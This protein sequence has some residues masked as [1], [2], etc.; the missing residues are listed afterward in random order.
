MKIRVGVLMGGASSERDI[1]LASGKMIADNLPKDRYD[2]VLLDTL[3]LMARNSNLP[4]HLQKRAHALLQGKTSEEVIAGE[5]KAALPENFQD[6]VRAASLSVGPA[7]EALTVGDPRSPIDVAFLALHGPYGEDGT[8]QGMLDLIGIPYVGS[9]CL[10][11][12]L[13]MDKA[14]AKKVFAADGIPTPR[15]VVIEKAAFAADPV[16]SAMSAVPLL[17]AVVKPSRQGSSIGMAMVNHGAGLEAALRTAFGYDDKVLV[18]ERVR[19]AE[20][21]VA[22]LGNDRPQALPVVEIVPK[23]DFFD[24]KAKYDPS[25]TDEICPARLP[26]AVSREAQALALRA[27]AS[28]DCRGLSRVDMIVSEDRGIVVLE[29]NTMP[30][31]T[32][33]SLFPKA[34]QAAGMSFPQL[35]DR[36]V[37]LALETK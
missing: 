8:L 31:M 9:G 2:V 28:L 19:G 14:M 13:A 11:S 1:S 36:L 24:Y 5:D 34:A 7:T 16:A 35:L 26:E 33:S 27:H 32:M 12:A 10:A 15:G 25:L 3:A 22:V 17:P 20:I 37:G 6:Q 21:T 30:G 4:A 29:V 18:E 23:R